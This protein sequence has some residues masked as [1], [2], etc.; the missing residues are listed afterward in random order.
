VVLHVQV[1]Q[2]VKFLQKGTKTLKPQSIL[3][4]ERSHLLLLVPQMMHFK[5]FEGC[6]CAVYLVG[7]ETG[8]TSKYKREGRQLVNRKCV[9]SWHYFRDTTRE[10]TKS[11]N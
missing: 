4:L 1:L 8:L 2:V 9:S 7:V 10:F 11:E 5:I 3:D 6:V